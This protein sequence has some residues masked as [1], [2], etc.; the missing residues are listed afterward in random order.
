MGDISSLDVCLRRSN[1]IKSANSKPKQ[2][3]NKMRIR[4]VAN[5]MWHI[6]IKNCRLGGVSCFMVFFHRVC[7]QLTK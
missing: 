4:T 2:I 5:F 7:T 1:A 3:M 6:L